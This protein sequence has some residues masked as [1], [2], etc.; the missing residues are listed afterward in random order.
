MNVPQN[1]PP[2]RQSRG[3]SDFRNAGSAIDSR[4][5]CGQSLSNRC[6]RYFLLIPNSTAWGI[7]CHPEVPY[8]A[9]HH[10]NSLLRIL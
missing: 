9:G 10:N 3:H 7:P 4:L 6:P 8:P 2:K 5:V 1:N